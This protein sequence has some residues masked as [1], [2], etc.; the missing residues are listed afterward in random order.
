MRGEKWV[1]A[2]ALVNAAVLAMVAVAAL[3]TA[4]ALAK[5]VDSAAQTFAGALICSVPF[6]MAWRGLNRKASPNLTNAAS[7]VNWASAFLMLLVFG[8]AAALSERMTS[9]TFRPVALGLLFVVNA[10]VLAFRKTEQSKRPEP[11]E[12]VWQSPSE[13]TDAITLSHAISLPAPEP[14]RTTPAN[15]FLRHWRG[16]LP[17]PVSYWINGGLLGVVTAGI[18]ASVATLERRTLASLRVVAVTTLA[19]LIA[20]LLSSGWSTVGIWRSADRH[21]SR[22]GASGWAFVARC[23]VVLGA[24]GGV[25][26]LVSSVLPQMR[27]FGLIAIGQDPIGRFRVS[28]SPDGHAVLVVGTLRE[29]AAAKIIDVL[30]ATPSAQW[31][32][33]DSNGGRVLEAQQ[34]AGAVRARRLDTYVERL[35]AS[36]CTYVFLAGRTRAAS[37]YARIGFHQP[38]FVGLNALGQ[39]RITQSMLDDYRAAGLPAEFIGQIARTP[40]RQM[41]YPGIAE[42]Q[43]ANVVTA[44]RRP[45]AVQAQ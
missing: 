36:A 18:F 19:V 16:E 25:I 43:R 17:L 22:G 13:G 3:S 27:V 10:K 29:G 37:P 40:P 21:A 30:D 28:V 44:I 42:L 11:I 31:L 41:W 5:G 12:P 45:P 7:V 6:A 34:L 32:V 23:M 38:S 8:I 26:N 33:L 35:C 14:E 24:I 4:A 9:G 20:S 39:Q 15:Y 2:M 1:R